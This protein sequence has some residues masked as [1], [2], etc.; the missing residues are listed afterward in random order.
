MALKSLL[1]PKDVVVFLVVENEAGLSRSTL[2]RPNLVSNIRSPCVVK[3]DLCPIILA[4]H[5]ISWTEAPTVK[6]MMKNSC[7]V[8]WANQ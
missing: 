6:R 3:T 8:K 4:A 1:I 7:Q 2:A 5:I